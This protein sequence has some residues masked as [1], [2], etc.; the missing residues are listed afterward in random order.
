MITYNGITDSMSGWAKRCGIT[1]QAMSL[2]LKRMT[3]E[4]A[5]SMTKYCQE[6][7]DY[8]D[9][10]DDLGHIIS[11]DI[12]EIRKGLFSQAELKRLEKIKKRKNLQI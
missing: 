3:V 4:N 1:K 12:E 2:R 8:A 9:K 7:G 11:D 10:I 6:R 5:L